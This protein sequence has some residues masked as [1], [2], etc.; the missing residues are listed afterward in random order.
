MLF[1]V[2]N[3][4]NSLIEYIIALYA[5]TRFAKYRF[6]WYFIL[7]RIGGDP[8][9]PL[10]DFDGS[11]IPEIEGPDLA[12]EGAEPPDAAE[13]D[14]LPPIDPDL[15]AP[16]IQEQVH[17]I[18][19]RVAAFYEVPAAEIISHSKATELSQAR[20]AAVLL[21]RQAG[22]PSA[23][24]AVCFGGRPQTSILRQAK[25]AA[26]K[27]QDDERFAEEI[28]ALQEGRPR[29]D[30]LGDTMEAVAAFYG[31][32]AVDVAAGEDFWAGRARRV[33]VTL[34]T[35]MD[36]T[37]QEKIGMVVGRSGATVAKIYLDAKRQLQ[38]D[39]RLKAEIAYLS[40]PA[41]SDRPPS[42]QD[43]LKNIAKAFGIKPSQL[44]EAREPEEQLAR[45][46]SVCILIDE[47]SLPYKELADMFGVS[48]T[49]INWYLRQTRQEIDRH[50]KR[51]LE[52]DKLKPPGSASVSL[53]TRILDMVTSRYKVELSDMSS[54]DQTP[55]LDRARSLAIN[56]L[57]KADYDAGQ[58]VGL[59]GVPESYV[60]SKTNGAFVNPDR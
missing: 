41:E 52:I 50:P 30:V 4:H 27:T 48:T 38:D 46:L 37:T 55:Y 18:I 35:E 2:I 57:L 53:A 54:N 13:G 33:F 12:H 28:T 34:M 26:E 5:A 59:L 60:R 43:I 8:E 31:I 20:K 17:G 23:Q 15:V 44:F 19:G 58:I 42:A 3:C 32:E 11:D 24:I 56:L 22:L 39:P 7:M 45:R 9:G 40:D 16:D 25:Q 47:L 6:L 14:V 1:K 36:Y 49:D 51:I 10:V 29:Q 21:C